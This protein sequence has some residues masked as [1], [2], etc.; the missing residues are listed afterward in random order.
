[1]HRIQLPGKILKFSSP[2]NGNKVSTLLWNW[3]QM[4]TYDYEDGLAAC[5]NTRLITTIFVNP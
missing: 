2:G 4:I 5:I 3:I 1:M